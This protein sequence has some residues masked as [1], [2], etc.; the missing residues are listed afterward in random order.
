[1]GN[2][3]REMMTMKR[4][5]FLRHA[6]LAAASLPLRGVA[7]KPPQEIRALLLHLGH[8]MW[9]DCLPND[10][11]NRQLIADNGRGLPDTVL[12]NRDDLWRKVTDHAARSGVNMIVIDLGKGVVYPSHPELAI[13]GSW[14]A[15][16]LKAEVGRLKAL[17]MEV[18]P[19]MNFSTSHNGWLK[20]YRRMISTRGYYQVCEDLIRDAAEIFGQPRLFHVGCDEELASHQQAFKCFQ[21]IVVRNRELWEHDFNHLVRTCEK[22]GMRCWAWS[23]YT[24]NHP[25]FL[26]RCP[27]SVLMSNWFYD[28]NNGGFE[29]ATNHTWARKQLQNFYDLE[30]YGFDQVPCGTNW[31]GGGRRK[32]KIGAD[33]VI[34]KLIRLCR[35]DV[36][37]NHLKG[38]MMAPWKSLDGEENFKTV[39]RAVDLFAEALKKK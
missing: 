30:K 20:H 2:D 37:A 14:S 34:G 21:Y 5:T 23:D 33:D 10:M 11:D 35:R 1:M 27:K 4:R 7:A 25:D 18:I 17:G 32:L 15:D 19:K 31:V 3:E 38:F 29:L 28:D 13:R 16:Q 22:N 8:N 12:R 39:M 6:A 9:C 26:Q 24:W 36:P